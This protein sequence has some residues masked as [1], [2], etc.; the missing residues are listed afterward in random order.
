VLLER[1]GLALESALRILVGRGGREARAG[2]LRTL[3]LVVGAR[4]LAD[5]PVAPRTEP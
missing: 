2:Q 1:A 3:L 5:A 4:G